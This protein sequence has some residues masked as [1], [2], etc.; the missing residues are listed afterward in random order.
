MRDKEVRRARD[1]SNGRE[2]VQ[3]Q[4]G[5]LTGQPEKVLLGLFKNPGT[6]ADFERNT[7]R[8]RSQYLLPLASGKMLFQ[9]V[10]KCNFREC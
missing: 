8:H 4:T 10:L 3:L 9:G 1:C 6:H 2:Q 7:S 5:V